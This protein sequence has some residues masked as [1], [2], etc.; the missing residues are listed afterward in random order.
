[1]QNIRA[2]GFLRAFPFLVP[3]MVG[4]LLLYT[5]PIIMSFA[6]SLTSWTGVRELEFLS[7]EFWKNNY[8]G[9][10]NYQKIFISEE[11]WKSLLHVG[12]FIVLYMPLMLVSSLGIAVLLNKPRKGIVLYRVLFY[13]PVITS[14]VAGAL[15]WRWILDPQFGPVNILLAQIGI[16]GPAWLQD[17]NWAMPGIV[18]A[19]VW[20]DM[21]FYGLI[22]LG[23]LK[24]INP[25]YYE[26][27][28]VDGAGWAQ[29]FFKI[30]I[31]MLTPMIF[32][33]MVIS[34]INAFMLFPQVMVM[35]EGGPH[36][37]TQVILERIYT[38]GFSYY[39]MGYASALSWMLFV[40]IFV[41]T[42]IQQKLQKKWVVYDV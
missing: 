15:I 21:G 40:I 2:K 10:Q 11:F 20:K 6:I 22:F 9:F 25:Q 16:D 3:S 35:T 39:E 42:Y 26:A 37:A 17:K 8:I 36:G 7:L 13:I 18:F 32:F 27:A 12:Y 31:P 33:V 28:Q 5:L 19:S 34:L 23:G 4:F 1:M 38:Y 24:S 41:F 29:R 14:W 30:T